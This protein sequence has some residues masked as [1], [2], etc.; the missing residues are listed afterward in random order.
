M[1]VQA[2]FQFGT[3]SLKQQDM[4]LLVSKLLLLKREDLHKH[5]NELTD[6]W[7]RCRPVLRCNAIG[8]YQVVHAANMLEMQWLSNHVDVT[9]VERPM[10]GYEEGGIL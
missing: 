3:T 9:V 1:L 7:R 2:G 5:T 10:N 8:W 4:L 6:C